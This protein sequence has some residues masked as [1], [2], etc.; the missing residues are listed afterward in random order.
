MQIPDFLCKTDFLCQAA[1]SVENALPVCS[2]LSLRADVAIEGD[3]LDV[4]FLGEFGNRGI[5]AL[6]GGLGKSNLGLGEGKLAATLPSPGAGGLE[7]GD[8]AFADQFTLEFR[9][10]GE[11]AEDE[12]A[13]RGCRVDLRALARQYTQAD[14]TLRELLHDTHEMVQVA[15][16]AIQ[17]PDDQGIA[18]AQCLEAVVKPGSAVLLAR[19]AVLIDE[20]LGHAV[21]R[22]GV[23]LE[24][25][26]LCVPGLGDAGV[27]DVHV[28]YGRIL[29]ANSKWCNFNTMTFRRVALL[30]PLASQG[31]VGYS[32][33][34]ITTT[35]TMM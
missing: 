32:H 28:L 11:D 35:D 13:G 31:Q 22:Q 14:P 16:K 19:G 33:P 5:A 27:S 21:G 29:L 26:V 9:Q 25:E 34:P 30:F 1:L 7:S 4:E 23:I 17:L 18:L 6:H 24:I 8:G 3:R 10:G 20:F 12:A 15:P 2:Q